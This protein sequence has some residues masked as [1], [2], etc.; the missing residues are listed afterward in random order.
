MTGRVS[1]RDAA[2]ELQMDV[3]TLRHLMQT[4]CLKIGY[5]SKRPG[6]KRGSYIIYRRLLD[7]E[8]ERLG[9]E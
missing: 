8:K 1:V 3:L 4:G 6:C 5:Y 2:Q 9:I 7:I